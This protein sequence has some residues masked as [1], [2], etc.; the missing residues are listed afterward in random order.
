MTQVNKTAIAKAAAAGASPGSGGI[1]TG[2]ISKYNDIV[3]NIRGLLGD[4]ERSGLIP[5]LNLPGAQGRRG[6]AGPAAGPGATPPTP[7]P[8]AQDISRLL[9]QGFGNF[10]AELEAAGLGD[11]NVFRALL[12]TDITV[13]QAKQLTDAISR[14][15]P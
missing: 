4:L 6:V 8:P 10:L 9:I 13:K 11:E 12:R 3:S 1:D 15:G 7:P 2:A 5:K 14:G